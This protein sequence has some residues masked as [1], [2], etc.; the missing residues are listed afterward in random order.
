MFTGLGATQVKLHLRRLVDLEYVLVHR[1]ER[2]HGVQYELLYDGQGTDGTPFLTGLL[3][4]TTL[5]RAY[6]LNRSDRKWQAVGGRSAPGRASVGGRS[7]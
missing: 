6:D 2:G 7:G 3:D 5:R 4:V 1:A